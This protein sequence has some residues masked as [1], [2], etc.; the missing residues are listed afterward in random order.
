[1]NYP[2]PSL[3]GS[4]FN[5]NNRTIKSIINHNNLSN[6][7]EG[8]LY[9]H[10]T[11]EQL[12]KID[13]YVSLNN[14]GLLSKNQYY[15]LT[16]MKNNINLNNSPYS[17]LIYG[18]NNGYIIQNEQLDR[19]IIKPSNINNEIGIT[20]NPINLLDLTTKLYVDS[21]LS[22]ITYNQSEIILNNTNLLLKTSELNNNV[23]NLISEGLP[24]G[25]ANNIPEN[26]DINQLNLYIDYKISKIELI[27]S[28]LILQNTTLI[29][30]I[31]EINLNV[32]NLIN[33]YNELLINK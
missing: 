10:L 15:E 26:I 1:M 5:N 30:Q 32:L 13:N 22:Q 27:N 25:C 23:L 6:I 19:F 9:K 31:S 29:E 16:R 28:Q 18:Y 24:W 17:G 14:D 33:K 8:E 3:N 2:K 11:T 20:D 21:K 4:I 7:N 12:N